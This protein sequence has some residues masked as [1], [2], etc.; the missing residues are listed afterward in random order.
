[1]EKKRS[2]AAA[3]EPYEIMDINY[4]IANVASQFAIIFSG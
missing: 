3:H 2:T 4:K 1:M